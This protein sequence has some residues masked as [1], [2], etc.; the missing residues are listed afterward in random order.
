MLSDLCRFEYWNRLHRLQ[1]TVI[2]LVLF[3]A[4]TFFLVRFQVDDTLDES[5]RELS[6]D[7][8]KQPLEEPAVKK[9][10]NRAILLEK[11]SANGR[12]A[13]ILTCRLVRIAIM[14][15]RVGTAPYRVGTA[16]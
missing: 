15:Y 1:K 6:R 14:P 9:P 10:P 2:L 16:P 7:R 3:L 5:S 8:N 12:T 4:I 13:L 11:V